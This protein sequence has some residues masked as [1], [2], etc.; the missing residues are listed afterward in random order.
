MCS[1][2]SVGIEVLEIEKCTVVRRQHDS[3]LAAASDRAQ[4]RVDRRGAAWEQ[5]KM[6]D[7]AYHQGQF[8]ISDGVWHRS[9]DAKVEERRLTEA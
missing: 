8:I 1:L 9:E 2:G 7:T 4:L 5:K 6:C 3:A